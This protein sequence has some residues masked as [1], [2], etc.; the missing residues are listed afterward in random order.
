MTSPATTDTQ[1]GDPA[2]ETRGAVVRRWITPPVAVA[3]ALAVWRIG[4]VGGEAQVV[5]GH[6]GA[7]WLTLALSGIALLAGTHAAMAWTYRWTRRP[8]WRGRWAARLAAV[9]ARAVVVLGSCAAWC[10]GMALLWLLS[11]G[12]FPSTFVSVGSA[13]GHDVVV[14]SSVSLAG[15]SL[16]GGFRDGL[17]VRFP[18]S[19]ESTWSEDGSSGDWRTH[20]DGYRVAVVG[21]EAVVS[22]RIDG[23]TAFTPVLRLALPRE[24]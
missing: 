14:E 22:A 23:G 7:E 19:A 6:W 8:R 3:S 17:V 1:P 15:T 4:L 20:A 11:I 10:C 24:G 12:G 5:I 21:D 18:R 2:D 9:L 16:A 13:R